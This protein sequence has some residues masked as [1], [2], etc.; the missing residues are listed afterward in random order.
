MSS[1]EKS[2]E[3]F[4]KL[5]RAVKCRDIDLVQEI[6]TTI[7]TEQQNLGRKVEFVQHVES[8]WSSGGSE[9]EL[10]FESILEIN[11]VYA[12][13]DVMAEHEYSIYDEDGNEVLVQGKWE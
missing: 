3:L 6:T 10:M 9:D 5:E 13:L 4:A 7:R 11:A 1:S 12:F 2:A 8:L